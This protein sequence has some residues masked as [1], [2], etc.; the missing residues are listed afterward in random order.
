MLPLYTLGAND[1]L[2]EQERTLAAT[3]ISSLNYGRA[4]YLPTSADVGVINL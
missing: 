1:V 4:T 3:G 2:L